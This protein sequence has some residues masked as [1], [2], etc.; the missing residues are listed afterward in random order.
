MSI[1]M[2]HD[3]TVIENK[4]MDGGDWSATYGLC[5]CGFESIK[6]T[7]SDRASQRSKNHILAHKKREEAKVPR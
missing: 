7:P 3:V 6:L 4:V 5:S 1:P 2:T